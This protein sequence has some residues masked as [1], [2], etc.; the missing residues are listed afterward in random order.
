MFL[1]CEA[2]DRNRPKNRLSSFEKKGTGLFTL[3]KETGKRIPVNKGTSG[4]NING[5]NTFTPSNNI[6]SYT[7]EF[8]LRRGKEV[9]VRNY[10]AGCY[11]KLKEKTAQK[12]Q[13]IVFYT[14]N[15]QKYSYS[16]K[17]DNTAVNVW[18]K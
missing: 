7:P 3:Q 2:D 5:V 16:A 10:I 12:L 17:V 4:E 9:G 18:Q 11:V 13:T 1:T 15:N 8:D 6:C 14:F